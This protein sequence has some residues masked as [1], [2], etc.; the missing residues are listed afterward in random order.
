VNLKDPNG[1]FTTVYCGSCASPT[2]CQSTPGYTGVGKCGG[3]S[4]IVYP[5][6]R[7]MIDMLEA[8]GEQDTTDYASQYAVCDNIKDGRGYTIGTVGFCTGTGDFIIVARCLN[9][10]EPSNT[11]SKYYPGLQKIDDLF[12]TTNMNIGDTSAVDSLGPF[13]TDVQAAGANDANYRK[14]QD[15]ISDTQYMDVA[16]QHAQEHGLHGAMTIGFLFDTELNFGDDDDPN[17]TAGAKTVIARADKDYGA[18]LPTDFTGLPWEESRW[19]G[20]LIKERTIVMATDPTGTWQQDMD[21]NATWEAARRL[22]TGKTNSPESGTDLSLGYEIVSAY[23]AGAAPGPC[24]PDL[25]NK[26]DSMTSI[27]SIAPVKTGTD[28][29]TWTA[30]D[31]GNAPNNYAACPANPTP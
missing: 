25:P 8:M 26:T 1:H 12:Y 18:G 28:P 21:Q 17:G 6:Q 27:S 16:L 3:N 31:T 7:Q 5:Y 20:Y 15:T 9:D 13:Q 19:L 22:H 24:W 14:C 2:W 4:A 10:V 30:Q 11:L 29:S 23:K